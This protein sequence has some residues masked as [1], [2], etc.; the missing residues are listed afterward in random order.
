MRL[1]SVFLILL[2]YAAKQMNFDAFKSIIEKPDNLG[3]TVAY[4]VATFSEVILSKLCEHKIS[5]NQITANFEVVEL[6]YPNLIS[7]MIKLGVNSRIYNLFMVNQH[8][9]IVKFH[10]NDEKLIK[11]SLSNAKS[12]YFSIQDQLCSIKCSTL[13]DSS[14]KRYI[15][16]NGIYLDPFKVKHIGSGSSGSVYAGSWHSNEAAFKFIPIRYY[17]SATD[18][19]Q[20]F[21]DLQEKISEFFH[22]QSTIG[23]NILQ[24]VGF[25][26]QQIEKDKTT[27]IHFDVIIYP[28]CDCNLYEFL[29]RYSISDNDIENILDQ[30]LRR[31]Q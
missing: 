21:Y 25:Y 14:L 6:K 10:S 3:R 29:N 22:Q 1:E 18:T 5:M 20:S 28:L 12:A 27:I 13:C 16:Q 31:N 19:L 11:Q 24:P 2:D 17:Q 26:R 4:N 23:E 8:Q 30:C 15:L 9:H 7:Q